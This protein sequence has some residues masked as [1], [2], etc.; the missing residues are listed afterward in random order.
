MAG[1]ARSRNTQ[2]SIHLHSTS[3]DLFWN[4]TSLRIIESHVSDPL[5]ETKATKNLL[6]K[7]DREL[8]AS[9]AKTNFDQ[10]IQQELGENA[11]GEAVA[12]VWRGISKGELN[13]KAYLEAPRVMKD[14]LRQII[15]RFGKERISWA[16]PECGLRGFPTYAS[17][18]EY[19]KRISETVSA[20]ALGLTRY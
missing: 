16:G 11:S 17:A 6:E 4:I 7:H 1:K 19:L 3:D 20:F 14:R 9:I 2:S 8:K 12:N 10:L 15:Q 13:P 18:I 5:Y